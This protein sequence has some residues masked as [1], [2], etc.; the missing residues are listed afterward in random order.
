[1]TSRDPQFT[2]LPTWISPLFLSD[3]AAAA[4]RERAVV[5]LVRRVAVGSA[6]LAAYSTLAPA[7]A[8]RWNERPSSPVMTLVVMGAISYWL[9][10]RGL[11]DAPNTSDPSH[12]AL[13]HFL[14][15]LLVLPVSLLLSLTVWGWP[16]ELNMTAGWLVSL[17]LCVAHSLLVLIAH[18]LLEGKTLQSVIQLRLLGDGYLLLSATAALSLANRPTFPAV[19]MAWALLDLLVLAVEEARARSALRRVLRGA[20]DTLQVARHGP[21]FLGNEILPLA[22]LGDDALVFVGPKKDR[23]TTFSGVLPEPLATHYLDPRRRGFVERW[24]LAHPFLSPLLDAPRTQDRA[25]ALAGREL[26]SMARSSGAI[27]GL[28]TAHFFAIVTHGSAPLAELGAFVLAGLSTWFAV[29]LGFHLSLRPLKATFAVTIGAILLSWALDILI[30]GVEGA[31]DSA[32]RHRGIYDLSWLLALALLPLPVAAHYAARL[33]HLESLQ[34]LAKLRLLHAAQLLLPILLWALH[35]YPDP[36]RY[37]LV[38]ALPC[39]GAFR[40][41]HFLRQESRARRELHRIFAGT[42]TRMHL[43]DESSVPRAS[44]ALPLSELVDG[45]PLTL[46]VGPRTSDYRESAAK[47]VALLLPHAIVARFAPGLAH[48]TL[49]IAGDDA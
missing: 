45:P 14:G 9:L 22:S 40:L 43:A 18:H 1:M 24:T 34:V 8:H 25:G 41:L 48:P 10:R 47:S 20:H 4:V 39:F 16:F 32:C 12:R 49:A 21:A 33:G 7:W 46:L 5:Q 38:L 42:S 35:L 37:P 27:A 3:F 6:V 30:H 29:M 28:F 31:C 23:G 13:L 19:C 44:E 15:S 26:E 2:Y 11:R 36:L 17:G